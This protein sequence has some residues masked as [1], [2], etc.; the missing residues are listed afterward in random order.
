VNGLHRKRTEIAGRLAAA[1]AEAA[2]LAK[3]LEALGATI[4]LF[5]PDAEL[6]ALRSSPTAPPHRLA[7]HGEVTRLAL[8]V[9]R[10]ALAMREV[11][12]GVMASCGFAGT[13]VLLVRAVHKR[14]GSALREMERRGVL[15]SEARDD[16]LP[17]WLVA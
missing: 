7:K 8:D 3:S 6:P 14:V 11:A 5:S 16:G 9:L 12:V 4:R 2:R 17:R 15:R 10:E 1:Q 13:D